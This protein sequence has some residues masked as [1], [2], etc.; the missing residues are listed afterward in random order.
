MARPLSDEKR[1]A[2]LDAAIDLF[3]ENGIDA[4][5]TAAISK[6][7]GVAEGSLFTYFRSKDGLVNA[8]YLELK[9]ELAQVL[10]QGLPRQGSI[11][12]KLEHLW[13][14]HLAWCTGSPKK[15]RTLERLLLS[16]RLDD[17]S[18]AQGA[19]P[20][21]ELDDA[22]QRAVDDGTLRDLSLP[23][24]HQVFQAM[25][26]ATLQMIASDPARAASYRREGFE[27]LWNAVR[28]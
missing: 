12:K 4:T 3:S 10:M 28:R 19:E 15:L 8:L 27:M 22:V 5:P 24:L 1:S 18:R 17:T 21:R 23:Y 2:L 25:V 16:N 11:A 7:A 20:F 26:T 6:A 13:N 9:A 14:R